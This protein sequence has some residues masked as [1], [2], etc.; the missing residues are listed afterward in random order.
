MS[1]REGDCQISMVGEPTI[2]DS[3]P[4]LDIKALLNK[5]DKFECQ[6]RD[7]RELPVPPSELCCP[8]SARK[9]MLK[10]TSPPAGRLAVCSPYL[11]DILQSK[12]A[13]Y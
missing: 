9:L 6:P 11:Q 8:L 5:Q 12:T 4:L 7:Q 2:W 1:L 3:A 13:A 10:V